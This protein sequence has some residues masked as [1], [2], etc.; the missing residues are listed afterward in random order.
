[1]HAQAAWPDIF[2]RPTLN[3]LGVAKLTEVPQP[4]FDSLARFSNG[5]DGQKNA[6]VRVIC[7]RGG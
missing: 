1:M 5:P 7:R 3:L 6:I 4:D 2:E